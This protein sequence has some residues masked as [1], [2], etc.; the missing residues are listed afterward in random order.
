M[1]DYDWISGGI[2]EELRD[3]RFAG[4]PWDTLLADAATEIERLRALITAWLDAEDDWQS[5]CSSRSPDDF[6]YNEPEVSERLGNAHDA[7]RQA[8]GR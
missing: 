4:E 7:L 3:N 5:I 8:V 1:N 6:Y 2:V